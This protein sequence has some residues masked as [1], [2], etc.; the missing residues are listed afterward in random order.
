MR[1]WRLMKGHQEDSAWLYDTF[2]PR[3]YRRLRWRYGSYGL[4]PDDLLQDAFVYFFQ[5]NGRVLGRFLER[6]PSD[7]D[8][9][10]L[11][12]FLWDQACGVA[13]N[14]LRSMKRRSVEGDAVDPALPD[15]V[16]GAQQF[17]D[18]DTLRRLDR[19]I[20]ERSRRIHLYFKLRFRNGLSPVEIC[21]MTGWSK[22]AIYKLRQRLTE[23]V[24]RCADSL[25]LALT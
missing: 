9:I 1:L 8:E 10:E 2:A 20:H 3:L 12:R 5:H 15:P 14:R 16:P 13:S 6:P 24:N 19:C 18:R 23:A 25:D 22:K 17:I 4:D 11:Q 21:Q 7:D